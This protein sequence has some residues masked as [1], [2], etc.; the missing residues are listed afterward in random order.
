MVIKKM[1]SDGVI[2]SH[3]KIVFNRINSKMSIQ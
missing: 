2:G 3:D 1:I